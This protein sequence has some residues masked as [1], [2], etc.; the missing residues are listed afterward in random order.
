M[1]S[2]IIKNIC[3]N[4]PKLFIRCKKFDT[5]LLILFTKAIIESKKQVEN[6]E[7]YV[8]AV[9]GALLEHKL[10][11]EGMNSEKRRDVIEGA[12]WAEARWGGVGSD[13]K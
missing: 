11:A 10:K 6:L 5:N 4:S 2:I 8:R 9:K 7:A 13:H 1:F 3:V 12:K